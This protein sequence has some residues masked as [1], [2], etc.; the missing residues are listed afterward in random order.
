V[1]SSQSPASTPTACSPANDQIADESASSKTITDAAPAEV[2]A[3]VS[4][5]AK[6][7]GSRGRRTAASEDWFASHG[8]FIAIGFVVALIG[9]VYFA[10]T[11]RQP[12]SSPKAEQASKTLV[13]DN[14]T[15]VSP[16]EM[17]ATTSVKTVAVV[18]DSK[19][20]LQ[21]PSAP[22]LIAKDE[23]ASK[24]PSSDKLFDFA[25]RQQDERMAA[26]PTTR[27]EVSTPPE[28]P[29]T[30]TEESKM[31][32]APTTNPSA[33]VLAPAYPVTGAPGGAYPATQSPAS[34]TN[35]PATYTNQFVGQTTQP[36]ASATGWAP[37][38]G[39]NTS[40]NQPLDNT[41][42]GPRYERTGSGHY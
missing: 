36:S 24:S 26:R 22:A 9:T 37:P 38:G 4:L 31:P 16:A 34:P 32:P 5:K 29:R 30:T 20:E 19:V 41:A 15:A 28:Q 17:S 12:S 18:S 40:Q 25:G 39:V 27:S 10:R 14:E 7:T 1:Q 13:A 35:S 3:P 8:K 23:P 42:R 6:T 33:P 2:T 21:R 11:N